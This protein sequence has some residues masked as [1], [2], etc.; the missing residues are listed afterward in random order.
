MSIKRNINARENA[1]VRSKADESAKRALENLSPSALYAISCV[2]PNVRNG[3]FWGFAKMRDVQEHAEAIKADSNLVARKIGADDVIIEV[4]PSYLLQN[5]ISVAPDVFTQQ[6]INTMN[7]NMA[8]AVVEFEKF[9]V[10]KGISTPGFG[11][12][13]GVYCTNKVTTIA[14]KGITYPAFRLSM[15][16]ALEIMAR[17]G[18][19]VKIGA[20][21]IPAAQAFGAGAALWQ[22]A[23]LAETKTGVFI[24]VKSTYTPEQLKEV[25][26]QLDVKYGRGKRQ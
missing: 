11:S 15:D 19:A 23:R 16:K 8:S 14:Y 21:F 26:K 13:I 17:C 22:S 5:I 18:Y 20:N 3:A 6:D 9:I 4:N 12:T 1:A 10:N 2:A 7:Q 25:K 24:N